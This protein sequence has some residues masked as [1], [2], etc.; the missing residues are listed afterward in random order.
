M[1]GLLEG[2]GRAGLYV[3]ALATVSACGGGST[4]VERVLF[5]GPVADA[6]YLGRTFPVVFLVG[7]GGDPEGRTVA[8][9]G[10][11]TYSASGDAVTVTLP[12]KAP[13][14]LVRSGTSGLGTIYSGTIPRSFAPSTD[15]DAVV[16]PFSSTSAFRLFSASEDGL[17]ILGGFGFET[18]FD[19]GRAT[20]SYTTAGAV[21]LTVDDVEDFLPVAGT[22][23]LTADFGAGT[24][25]GTLIDTDAFEVEL[26]GDDT[27]DDI[28]DFRM[29]LE[30]GRISQTG[31]SGDLGVAAELTVD[32]STLTTPGVTVTGDS[33]S[34][35][36]FGGDAEAVAG[37]YRGNIALSDGGGPIETFGASGFFSGAKD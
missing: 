6:D 11:I 27:I 24:I 9:Q 5:E 12:G 33:A 2:R 32:G 35:T 4:E 30:N 16:T 19:P 31:F 23:S 13:I 17:A 22:G 1:A 14:E 34:G 28:L 8:G 29:T 18:P 20:A 10:T 25:G 15:V 26:A 3:L 21:F 7:E 37:S 36:F